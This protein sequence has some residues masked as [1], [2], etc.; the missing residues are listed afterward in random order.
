MEYKILILRR[1]Q[2][3]VKNMYVGLY[4]KHLLLLSDFALLKPT[5]HVMQPT[6]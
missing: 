3:D 2:G 1:T 6:V 5:G 4:V